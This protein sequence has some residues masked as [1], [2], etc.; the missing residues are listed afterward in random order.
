MDDRNS[1]LFDV[2]NGVSYE[3]YLPSLYPIHSLTT[4]RNLATIICAPASPQ[5]VEYFHE[6]NPEYI[7]LLVSAWEIGEVPGPLIIAPLSELYGRAPIYLLTSVLFVLFSVGGALS[8]SANMVI[9]FRALTGLAVASSALNPAIIGD[10]FIQEERGGAMAVMTFTSLIGVVLGPVVGGFASARLGWRWTFWVVAIASGFCT[11]GLAIFLKETYTHTILEKKTKS[12]RKATGNQNLVSKYHKDG[13]KTSIFAEAIIRPIK[14]FILSPVLIAISLY[15]DVLYGTL[16]TL[17][18]T[19]TVMLEEQYHFSAE[20][21]GL[22]F[23]GV[24]EFSS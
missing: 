23:I 15:T 21:A 18:T 9:V 2:F 24:G 13:S 6:K 20:S 3:N 1:G 10:L 14:L 19:L 12:L 4:G 17:L 7:T 22:S 8:T 5:I 11:L 16:Y